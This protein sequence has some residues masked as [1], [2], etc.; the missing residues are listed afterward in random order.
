MRLQVQQGFSYIS[1]GYSK[2]AFKEGHEP[3]NQSHK[4]RQV[5]I[6]NAVTTVGSDNFRLTEEYL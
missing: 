2:W 3:V 6:V 1:S 5:L 4:A